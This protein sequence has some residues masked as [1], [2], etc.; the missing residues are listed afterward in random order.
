VALYGQINELN[1]PLWV[2]MALPLEWLAAITGAL[3]HELLVAAICLLSL[4]CALFVGNLGRFEGPVERALAMVATLCVGIFTSLY[5]FGQREQIVLIAAIPYAFLIAMRLDERK[6]HPALAFAV[7]LVASF[8]FALKHYFALVPLLLELLLLFRQRRQYR[9]IRVETMTLAGVALTYVGAI[10]LFAPDF[11]HRIVPMVTLAY[12]GY[13]S[14]LWM[15]FDE[16]AQVIWALTILSLGVTG[17]WR[18]LSGHADVQALGVSMVGFFLAYIAQRKGWQYHAIS[19]SGMATMLLASVGFS[20]PQ[21]VRDFDS[22]P[23]AVSFAMTIFQG[24]YFSHREKLAGVLVD[25]VA[26]GGTVMVIASNPMWGWPTVEDRNLV[27]ASR[28]YAHWMIPAI[29]RARADHTDSPAMR[30]RER[31]VKDETFADMACA[32]PALILIEN[33]EPNFITRPDDF[34]TLAFFSEDARFRDYLASNYHQ[35]VDGH[36]LRAFYRI[37]PRVPAA[38]SCRRVW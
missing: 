31:T 23:L 22:R 17:L 28:Y 1:P 18:R 3:P 36:W 15:C 11:V 12:A 35:E 10:L 21:R 20:A 37:T 26:K 14:P 2:W 16:P 8:G 7:A 34:D 33:H 29:G 27:W 24:P 13:E 32:S 25:R 19:T 5:D 4:V 30:A 38:A 6:P 9:A